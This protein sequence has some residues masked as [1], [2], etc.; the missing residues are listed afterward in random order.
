LILANA[1]E[2]HTSEKDW[3]EENY[4]VTSHVAEFWNALSSMTM[5]LVNSG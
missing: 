3:C 2:P 5:L 1:S 4:A